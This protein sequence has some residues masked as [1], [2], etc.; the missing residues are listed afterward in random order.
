MAK[1]RFQDEDLLML[2]ERTREKMFEAAD[3]FGMRSPEVQ[4]LSCEIDEL[5]NDYMGVKS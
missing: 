4:A 3:L 2:I 1:Q 5:S